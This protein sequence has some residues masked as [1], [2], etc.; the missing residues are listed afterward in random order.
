MVVFKTTIRLCTTKPCEHVSSS[1][2]KLKVT[3]WATETQRMS[4]IQR[5]KLTNSHSVSNQNWDESFHA[6]E[7]ALEVELLSAINPPK[8]NNFTLKLWN[9]IWIS[10][11]CHLHS[12]N[13]APSF[14]TNLLLRNGIIYKVGH[15]NCSILLSTLFYFI[16]R[17]FFF[18][19][20]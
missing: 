17:S 6:F 11:E 14:T 4:S 16:M 3:Y 20:K 7:C 8:N 18:E 2:S 1:A 5:W 13:F 12:R 9:A 19:D 15:K 10:D